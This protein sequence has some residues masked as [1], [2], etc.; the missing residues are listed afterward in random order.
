M[1]YFPDSYIEWNWESVIE[2]L[3]NETEL[4]LANSND[5]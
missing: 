4:P 5:Y 1:A 3:C 2:F